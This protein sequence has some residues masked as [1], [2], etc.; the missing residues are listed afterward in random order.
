MRE[1]S[2][3]FIAIG[4]PLP[5]PLITFSIGT[6]QSSSSRTQVSEE[7]MPNFSSFFPTLNPSMLESTMK[8][9][10]PPCFLTP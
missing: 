7:R 6:L 8:A 2:N 3:A 1:L 5:A 4:K 9:V 10:V